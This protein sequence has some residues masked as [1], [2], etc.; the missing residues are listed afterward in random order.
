MSWRLLCASM[1]TLFGGPLPPSVDYCP[2]F[3]FVYVAAPAVL[4]CPR[5][6]CVVKTRASRGVRGVCD[7]AGWKNLGKMRVLFFS[8][9]AV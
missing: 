2:C 1:C 7:L 6:R 3:E 5:H 8:C 4:Q 9:A